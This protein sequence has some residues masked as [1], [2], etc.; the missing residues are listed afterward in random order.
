MSTS[1]FPDVFRSLLSKETRVST[2]SPLQKSIVEKAYYKGLGFE[3][4]H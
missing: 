1:V 4:R 3:G 2:I